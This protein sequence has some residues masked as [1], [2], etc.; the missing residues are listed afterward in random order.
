LS[1]LP[2]QPRET[3]GCSRLLEA[4]VSGSARLSGILPA[5]LERHNGFERRLG[6]MRALKARRWKP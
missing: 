6:P 2:R 3:A 5:E 4:G 1:E